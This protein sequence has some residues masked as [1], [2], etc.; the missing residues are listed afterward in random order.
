L[1]HVQA[2]HKIGSLNEKPLHRALKKWYA[3]PD[4]R[5][6]VPVDGFVIDVVHGDLLVEIQ[7]A[8]FSAIKRK[9]AA[10]TAQHPVRLVYPIA[11]EKWI[12]RL[13]KDGNGQLG[14]RKS[15]KRGALE[16]VFGELVSFPHLLSNPNFSLDVLLIQEEEI[17]RYDRKRG[18]RRKGWV[19]HERRLLQVV[20]NRLF[21]TPADMAALLPADLAEPFA[22]SDLA[23]AIAKPRRLAQKM[24]YCLREMGVIAAVG[25]RGNAILY[26][27]Q[28]D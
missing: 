23:A 15:P 20:D 2:S 4:D 17:R 19:T 18:W 21:E 8:S 12:V 26:R 24:A 7:T 11:R 13:A 5:F 27:K 9:L 14:R 3:R 6:E 25:K 16:Q 22:T 1:K 10:L 28:A